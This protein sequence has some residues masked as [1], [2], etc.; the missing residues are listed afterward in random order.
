LKIFGL[1]FPPKKKAPTPV[2]PTVA[3]DK[4]PDS[5]LM[6]AAYRAAGV[7]DGS[8]FPT[9]LPA[10]NQVLLT[11]YWTLR[12]HSSQFFKTNLYARGL[13]RRLVTNEI[14]TGLGV[15]SMPDEKILGV[16]PGSLDDWTDTVEN[17]FHLW[18]KNP[19]ICDFR[20][21]KTLGA[22]QADARREAL[23]SGDVLV[24]LRPAPNGSPRVQLVS[25]EAV[26]TPFM[27]NVKLK[28]GHDIIEGVEIDGQGRQVAYWVT[29]YDDGEFLESKRIPARSSKTGRRL[30]WLVYGCDKRA[31]EVRG[32]PLLALVLQSLSEID[33][34]RDSVQRKAYINSVLA[35]FI[36][37]AED[38]PG[39][40]PVGGG[41]VRRDTVPVTDGDGATR[42]YQ[43]ASEIPGMVVEE[44]QTGEEPV[45][46]NS[47]GIDL[48][49]GPFE[50]SII[51][52]IAWV[53]EIPPEILKLAFSNNYSASQAAINEYKIYLNM[54]RMNF[55]DCFCQPIF[56]DWFLS[57]V[58]LGKIE[59]PG[60]LAAWNN[61]DQWDIFGAYVAADW[62]GAIKLSTD[63]KK[64]AEGYTRM[65]NQGWITN[66]RASKELSGTK[67]DKNIRR[68]ERENS[69][70]VQ[71]ATPLAEFRK[72]YGESAATE[73]IG[74]VEESLD[75]VDEAIEE[76]EG[77]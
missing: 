24:V 5:K 6:G 50:E 42:N 57:E 29:Q 30:A 38:K 77:E 39:T 2:L 34:Y 58:L 1:N 19:D 15:E 28:P 52:A 41:A 48:A 35:M 16:E 68:I 61:P 10:V 67:F 60:F 66:A 3:V 36:K 37:K 40:L 56:D 74:D 75:D 17:R 18:G 65:V 9:G 22:I 13:I 64:Q 12:E 23:I 31:F 63:I 14:N 76:T 72:K 4:L 70:K 54:V 51:H 27:R 46:F 32:E 49:F 45:G 71:A 33:K 43:I 62:S 25:G 20:Q 47:Q 44:L 21:A 55:G 59:A 53:N 7:W 69:L 26:Q 73:A 8:K 11:D